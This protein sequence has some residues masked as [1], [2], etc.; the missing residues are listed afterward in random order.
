[1]V[2]DHEAPNES[3]RED[4]LEVQYVVLLRHGARDLAFDCPREKHALAN[5]DRTPEERFGY[6]IA[7]RRRPGRPATESLAGWLA[8]AL[9]SHGIKVAQ[10]WHSPQRHAKETLDCAL[11][12]LQP[13]DLLDGAFKPISKA[14]LDPKV[15]WNDN[16]ACDR[17]AKSIRPKTNGRALLVAGHQPAL[18]WLC[19]LLTARFPSF[20][21]A[22]RV[23]PLRQSEA[24]CLQLTPKLRLTWAIA[25]DDRKTSEQLREKIKSKMDAAKLLAGFASAVIGLLFRDIAA[26]ASNPQNRTELIYIAVASVVASLALSFGAFLSYDRLLMPP[27]FWSGRPA[28]LRELVNKTTL[29]RPPTQTHW[30]LYDSMIRIWRLEFLPAATLFATGL[31]LLVF[32]VVTPATQYTVLV[33]AIAIGI[34]ALLHSWSRPALGFD[35]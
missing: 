35:D 32:A 2:P 29:V 22:R 9:Q 23:L 31:V 20:L 11:S 8:E 27:L 15:F 26:A 14:E 17:L 6:H 30:L 24:A 28:T 16:K 19:R 34:P 12:A 13:Q 18:G 7:N 3:Q 4:T 25:G 5:L 1:M 21:M 10:A 33:A